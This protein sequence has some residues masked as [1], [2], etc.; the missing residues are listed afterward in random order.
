MLLGAVSAVVLLLSLS[1][2][3]VDETRTALAFGWVN[4]RGGLPAGPALEMAADQQYPQS[5]TTLGKP[6]IPEP[7][8]FLTAE[9]K[10]VIV[11]SLCHTG[12]S[13]T[14]DGSTR[15]WAAIRFR[16]T[17]GWIRS[18]RT[19]CAASFN[20][21]TIQEVVSGDRDQIME[22]LSR[23]LKEQAKQLDRHRG[24]GISGSICHRMSAIRYLAA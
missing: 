20:K 14:C 18:S 9:R 11:D 21:R 15:R 17:C 5:L 16:L 24:R 8:R 6:W 19:A 4:G 12:A 3:T 23:L 13:R 22:T 2:F 7:E 1:L 10:N